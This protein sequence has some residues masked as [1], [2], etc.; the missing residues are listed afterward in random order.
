[1][2]VLA[3]EQK[4]L[5]TPCETSPAPGVT[6]GTTPGTTPGGISGSA[7][8]QTGEYMPAY[9]TAPP[10]YVTRV[11][12]AR[13][14]EE[15]RLSWQLGYEV[16]LATGLIDAN[17]YQMH[18]SMQMVQSGAVVL[19]RM[20]N[21]RVEA[22]LSAVAD[23]VEGLPL[24]AVYRRELDLLRL[25]G[26]KLVEVGQFAH[27]WRGHWADQDAPPAGDR[28]AVRMAQKAL[29]ELTGYAFAY[30][31]S[32]GATDFVIGVHPRHS[33]FY[34]HAWGFM[35]VGEMHSYPSVNHR[36]VVLLCGDWRAAM[37][38]Q[39]IPFALHQLMHHPIDTGIYQQRYNFDSLELSGTD[40]DAYLRWKV[41]A[42][43]AGQRQLSA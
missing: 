12:V 27:R 29:T 37:H 21:R 6:P 18:T 15:V 10:V 5:S 35:R 41:W 14:L 9:V 40:L 16:Y 2:K 28:G 4:R 42:H 11:R 36:P 23:G 3:A 32:I 39:P 24:D 38:Y 43:Q 20:Y 22:T 13:T 8:S 30:G 33:R 26:R 19:Q 7:L 34:Q 25:N 31:L 17:P 1:M